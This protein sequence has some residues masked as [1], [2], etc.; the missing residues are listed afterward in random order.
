MQVCTSL[1]TDNHAS[2]PPLCF[3]QA[4]CPSCRPTNSVKALKAK[5]ACIFFSLNNHHHKTTISISI[6]FLA[7]DTPLIQ[8]LFHQLQ[9]KIEIFILWINY[10]CKQSYTCTF[11]I[12]LHRCQ[13]TVTVIIMTAVAYQPNTESKR[14]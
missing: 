14:R 7:Q 9:T 10:F 4:G 12:Q 3:L 2:T 8:Y 5:D 13:L 11:Q 1:Q 6:H